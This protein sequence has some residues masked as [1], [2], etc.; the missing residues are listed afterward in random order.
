MRKLQSKLDVMALDIIFG[1]FMC[2]MI[3][4]RCMIL[5]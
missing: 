5:L 1:P 2:T 3:S 4:S